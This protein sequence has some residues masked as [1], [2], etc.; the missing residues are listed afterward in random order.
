MC[1]RK[2]QAVRLHTTWAMAMDMGQLR[3]G[4]V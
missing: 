2:N 4:M 3:D 1:G